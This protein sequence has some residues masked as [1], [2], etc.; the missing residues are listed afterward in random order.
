MWYVY[1]TVYLSSVKK[2]EIMGFVDKW[3]ELEKIIR[4]Q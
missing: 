1:T 3:M 2:D 4:V